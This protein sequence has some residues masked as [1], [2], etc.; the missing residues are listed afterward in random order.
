MFSMTSSLLLLLPL[1]SQK[2]KR[3]DFWKRNKSVAGRALGQGRL[4]YTFPITAE[5][6]S[7]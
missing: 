7:S 1:V 5:A 2:Q 3:G 6:Y 4:L